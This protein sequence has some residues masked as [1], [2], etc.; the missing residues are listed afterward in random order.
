MSGPAVC[1][2]VM[3]AT[4]LV[5]AWLVLSGPGWMDFW[6]ARTCW[7][8][9]RWERSRFAVYFLGCLSPVVVV[10]GVCGGV[11]TSMLAKGAR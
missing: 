1:L 6:Y 3:L 10:W 7:M 11:A 2:A 4:L 8:R 5:N 9:G